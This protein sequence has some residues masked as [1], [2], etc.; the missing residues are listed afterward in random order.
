VLLAGR[1]GDLDLSVRDVAE[2]G[3]NAL[4]AAL[5]VLGAGTL[6][7]GLIPRLA[8]TLTYGLVAASFLLE[9]VGSTA[10]L[11]AWLLNLSV[12]HHVAPAPAV[13]PAWG[14]ALVLMLLGLLAALGGAAALARR[15]IE[16]A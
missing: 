11:P 8:S 2:A 13:E 5:F 6:L 16:T 4:P 14:S 15:D 1:A 12:M 9:V 7:H 3:V 10:G